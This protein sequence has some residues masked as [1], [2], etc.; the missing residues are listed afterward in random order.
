MIYPYLHLQLENLDGE[1][2]KDIEEFEGIYQ[3]SSLGRI[4]SLDR[5]VNHRSG[6]PLF[7]IG[8]VL[9]QTMYRYKNAH[10]KDMIIA[11][12]VALSKENKRY[13][14]QVR[15]LV[16]DAFVGKLDP[17]KDIVNV[18]GNGFNN[19]IDNISM[20]DKKQKQQRSILR[21][22]VIPSLVY[23]DRSNFKKTWGGYSRQKPI[24][25]LS[26][27]GVLIKEFPSIAEAVRQTGHDEKSIINV[28][29]GRWSHH[30]N[31]IWKY[32]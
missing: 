5:Y 6:K 8:V 23:L 10:T 16:Y 26:L 2:W 29:K 27:E 31:F 15:R 22:R 3:V 1:E 21:N 13:D 19:Q 7:I 12:R 28:A 25:Q 11:L 14:Y 20:L 30:H 4:K 32:K 9:S 24:Q 17:K 18:D